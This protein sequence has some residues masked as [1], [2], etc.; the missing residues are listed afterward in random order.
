MKTLS[1]MSLTIKT[2]FIKQTGK[3]VGP[4]SKNTI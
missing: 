3:L 4:G 2:V 1:I